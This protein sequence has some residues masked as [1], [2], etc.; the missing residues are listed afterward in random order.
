MEYET[1]KEYAYKIYEALNKLAEEVNDA[2]VIISE[3]CEDEWVI[4]NMVLRVS[5]FN[6]EEVGYSVNINPELHP[7]DILYYVDELTANFPE[8]TRYEPYYEDEYTEVLWN[9]DAE[10]ARLGRVVEN[11]D[12]SV[13]P[14]VTIH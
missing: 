1:N 2:T 4:Y 11:D 12:E 13:P 5:V 14:N 7:Y 9:E 8:L 3:V 6:D 10:E